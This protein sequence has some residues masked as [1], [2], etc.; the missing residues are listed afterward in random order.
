MQVLSTD[1]VPTQDAFAY[2]RDVLT[3]HFIHLRPERIGFPSRECVRGPSAFTVGHG[4]LRAHL[5]ISC[6]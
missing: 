1:A 5:V 4:K 2:W 6:F 3:Q